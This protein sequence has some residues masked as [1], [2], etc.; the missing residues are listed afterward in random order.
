MTIREENE[1]LK[2]N[3][4]IN[5]FGSYLIDFTLPVDAPTGYYNVS[6]SFTNGST[7]DYNLFSL[8]QSFRVEEYKA[9]EI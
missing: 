5:E 4:E 8:S 1:I 7:N 9:L 3:V 2:G 6:V